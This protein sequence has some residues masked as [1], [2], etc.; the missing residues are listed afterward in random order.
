MQLLLF[1]FVSKKGKR[2]FYPMKKI[3]LLLCVMIACM[4]T[5]ADTKRVLFIGNSYTGVNNLPLLLQNL[6]SSAGDT[7]VFESNTP[8]GFTFEGHSTNPTTL[9]KIA[10]GTWDFVVLQEQS[11][12]PSFPD[13]QVATQVFP[14]AR[15]LDSLIQAANPCTKTLFYMTWGRKNGDA[16]N[17][18]NFPPLCTYAGMDSLLNLRYRMMADSNLAEVCPAGLVWRRI[19]QQFPWMELYDTDGS[20]PSLLG[21]Y[22]TAC[23]FYASVFRKNPMLITHNAGLADSTAARSRAM[24]AQVVFDSLPQWNVNR[25]LPEAAGTASAQEMQVSGM[26]SSLHATSIT[27]FTGD[28]ASYSGNE[29]NH[30]YTNPG[31]YV[32][33]LVA[34]DG[35]ITD[36]LAIPVSV[37]TGMPRMESHTSLFSVIQQTN[38]S[39]LLKCT[40]AGI[41]LTLMDVTGRQFLVKQADE[42]YGLQLMDL[43]SGIYLLSATGAA[44]ERQTEKLFV[45]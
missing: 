22:T 32:V 38:G 10:L 30:T 6:A 43:P 13:F 45:K 7:L 40:G 20:H 41:L 33:L 26:S 4:R 15:L 29:L 44:G 24:A 28:G 21:S 23:A 37:I 31:N 34:G 25:W 9:S 39:L 19:R 2:Y 3:L 8:G 42:E 1:Y 12:R 36:T 17:C 35:C 11:Q 16:S 5:S 27:W 18:A 14:Y